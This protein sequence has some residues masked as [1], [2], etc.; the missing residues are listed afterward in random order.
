MWPLS[1]GQKVMGNF[2]VVNRIES[3]KKSSNGHM[4]FCDSGLRGD[5]P[6][7]Y[8]QYLSLLSVVF[9]CWSLIT[10]E[11]NK[12]MLSHACSRLMTSSSRQSHLT[13]A[14][15]LGCLVIKKVQL[16]GKKK[17]K[18]AVAVQYI[19][20]YQYQA[21][22]QSTNLVKFNGLESNLVYPRYSHCISV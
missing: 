20:I 19:V 17:Q 21:F 6:S 7:P 5:L 11:R 13:E 12:E 3:N 8:L 16:L 2:T 15:R 14:Q 18:H 10:E 4:S 22:I 1:P 9:L